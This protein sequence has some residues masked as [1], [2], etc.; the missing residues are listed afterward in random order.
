[1]VRLR[2]LIVNGGWPAANGRGKIALAAFAIWVYHPLAS[3]AYCLGA[4][5]HGGKGDASRRTVV[6]TLKSAALLVV[7]LGVLYGV[8]MALNKADPPE[9]GDSSGESASPLIEYNGNSVTGGGPLSPS[10]VGGYDDSASSAARAAPGGAYPSQLDSGAMPPPTT[11]P[12]GA[13]P[14]TSSGGLA[15]STYEQSADS[16]ASIGTASGTTSPTSSASGAPQLELTPAASATA[17]AAADAASPALA[18]YALRRDLGEAEQLVSEGKYR[19]ALAK[20]TPHYTHT[21]LPPD[22]RAVLFSWLDALA[23]KVI[24]SREHLLTAAHQVRKGET[25]YDVAHQ[26]NVEYR[27]LQNINSRDVSDPLILVPATELKV[28][29]GP[30]K[31]DVNLA[32]GEVTLLVNDLYAGR[33]SFVVGDQPPQPGDYRV[34]DKRSQQK[35]YVGFDGRMIPANDPANPY[36]GWWISLGGEVAIHGSPTTPG[37]MTLGCIS[38]SPSDA[39]DV[40]GIVSIGSDVKIHR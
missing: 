6:N 22:Q 15:R 39:K 9:R 27:L 10:T 13:P 37:S 17:Q 32:T 11:V 8:Y 18:A 21:E 3:F 2:A 5:F 40:Y 19:A 36:G 1:M 23:G 29:P 26:Y 28:V 38:L 31:A 25:L 4:R 20:L 30:F 14:L 34:V 33:F 24:Y 7:L 35:T 12:S 16:P